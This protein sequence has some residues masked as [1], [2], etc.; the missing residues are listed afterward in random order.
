MLEKE[1]PPLP[2]PLKIP[3][4][5]S[6]HQGVYGSNLLY[7]VEALANALE[8]PLN[9]PVRLHA[10]VVSLYRKCTIRFG[11]PSDAP[12]SMKE[13]AELPQSSSLRY[14]PRNESMDPRWER[15]ARSLE[16][17]EPGAPLSLRALSPEEMA[18]IASGARELSAIFAQSSL[19]PI[20]PSIVAAFS[21]TS[22]EQ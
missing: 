9:E 15:L 2:E 11:I 1:A 17:S 19:S 14:G 13:A 18:K 10:T 20:H 21:T 16:V 5:N 6:L 7:P 4:E 3:R 22:E 8:C 12:R